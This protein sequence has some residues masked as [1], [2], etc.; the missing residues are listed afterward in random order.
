[1]LEYFWHFDFQDSKEVQRIVRPWI[2]EKDIDYIEKATSLIEALNLEFTGT[3]AHIS[4]I[5]H[6]LLSVKQ[7]AE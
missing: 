7:L 5:K 1:M 4:K 2:S 3:S 6:L